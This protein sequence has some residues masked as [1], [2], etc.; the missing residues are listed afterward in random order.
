M[1]RI[2][3][4]LQIYAGNQKIIRRSLGLSNTNQ[5]DLLVITAWSRVHQEAE[6]LLE[7]ELLLALQPHLLYHLIVLMLKQ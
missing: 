6:M 3:P 1:R 2:A 7:Q 4:E 5:A